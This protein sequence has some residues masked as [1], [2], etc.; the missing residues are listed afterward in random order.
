MS[1]IKLTDGEPEQVDLE[2][3]DSQPGKQSEMKQQSPIVI[4]VNSSATAVRR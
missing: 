4:D 3:L 2:N 1:D